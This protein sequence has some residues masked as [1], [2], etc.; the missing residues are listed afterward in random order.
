[1]KKETVLQ[2]KGQAAEYYKKAG[3]M[4]TSEEREKIEVA[5]FGLHDVYVI[6]LESIVYMNTE[7]VCAKEMV[8]LP[9]Q[10]CPEHMH[11]PIGSYI[12]KEETFRCR[13]GQ[14]YLYVEG[15]S[16]AEI[17]AEVPENGKEYFTVFHE[18]VLSQG[19]QYT[20]LPGIKHWF[21][22]GDMGAVVSEF[23]TRCYDENDIFTDPRIKRIPEI[24]N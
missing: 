18:I 6:G 12:G 15:E 11:P 9:R 3:I 1:M 23:S 22:A 21:Q 13:Y 4:I 19:E 14:V 10:T 5:D 24:E 16:T 2:L 17:Q 8:L 20:L 7:R